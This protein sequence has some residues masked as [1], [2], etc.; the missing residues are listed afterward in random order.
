M[1]LDICQTK[2][3]T[4]GA[5][6]TAATHLHIRE[7]KMN[8]HEEHEVKEF[9][10]LIVCLITVQLRVGFNFLTCLFQVAEVDPNLGQVVV[11]CLGVVQ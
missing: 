4:V 3:K 9:D 8:H 5:T 1:Y 2:N 10:V 7:K 11:D 6:A